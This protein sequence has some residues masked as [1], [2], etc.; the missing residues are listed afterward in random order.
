MKQNYTEQ[1]LSVKEIIKYEKRLRALRLPRLCHCDFAGD[2]GQSP[3]T[4]DVMWEYADHFEEMLDEGA[5]MV[6]YG[7]PGA[8]KS[9]AAAQI[10]NELTD[11]GYNCLF[12]SMN[13]I[14]T[15]LNTSSLE[16]RR[17]L[18]AQIFEKDL[19]VLDD[20]GS[21]VET[22]Y[23]NQIFIQIVNTCLD[24]GIPIIVTTPY[25]EDALL[26][27]GGNAKRVMAFSRLLKRSLTYTVPL[28]QERRARELQQKQRMEALVKGAASQ[29]ALTGFEG[30]EMD[31]QE[32]TVMECLPETAQQT[33]PLN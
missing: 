26:K 31:W 15:E 12:T 8:G 21:E 29:Q 5:G 17:N 30:T 11:R 23:C 13:S 7:S 27:E 19:L 3:V 22:P 16:G 10:V 33:L 6:I 32:T 20:L 2:N 4:K 28:P 14:M 1:N 25:Q 18:L 24:R 9:H